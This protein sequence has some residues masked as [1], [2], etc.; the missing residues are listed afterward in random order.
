[1]GVEARS[2]ALLTDGEGGEAL[3]REAIER[4]RRTKVASEVARTHLLYGEALRRNGRR[5]YV[6]PDPNIRLNR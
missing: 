3:Y 2:R 6:A 1:M 4:L 5:R